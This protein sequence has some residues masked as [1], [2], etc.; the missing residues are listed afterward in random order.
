MTKTIANWPASS[1]L[2]TLM[3]IVAGTVL[4]V[5]AQTRRRPRR[6]APVRVATIPYYTV[7]ADTIMRARI[8]EE[9]NS[10]TARIGDRFSAN[11]T[12]PVFTSSG[13]EVIPV[14]SKVWDAVWRESSAENVGR[15][16][17]PS[18]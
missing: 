14:G 13:I 2:L 10:G 18:H 4:D 1:L 5:S 6:R 16:I 12:E 15:E 17:S 9:L 3:I 8:N 7:P 11:V